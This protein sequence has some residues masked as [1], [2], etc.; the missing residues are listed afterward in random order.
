QFARTKT[1]KGDAVAMI[2]IHIGLDLE[3][4][5]GHRVFMG[6]H[7]ARIGS[8]GAWRR[9]ER[10]ERIEKILHAKVLQRRAEEHRRE[11]AFAERLEIKRVASVFDQR[12]LVADG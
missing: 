7:D 10:R 2:G 3:D 9:S 1:G 5:S 11:M 8:L 4:E 6:I 12:Q